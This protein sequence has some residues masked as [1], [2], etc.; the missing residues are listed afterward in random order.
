MVAPRC[1][2]ATVTTNRTLT[3]Q[4]LTRTLGVTQ[5]EHP[6]GA[7]DRLAVPRTGAGMSV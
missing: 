1:V 2:D 3:T 7:R 6:L 5:F 4:L